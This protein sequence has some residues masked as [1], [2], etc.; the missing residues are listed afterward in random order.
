MK[1]DSVKRPLKPS[2]RESI[3]DFT[4]GFGNEGAY[5]NKIIFKKTVRIILIVISILIIMYIGFFFTELLISISELP[6]H[7]HFSPEES[8]KWISSLIIQG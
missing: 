6:A 1:K 8:F 4:S 7:I 2:Q 3:T 5:H